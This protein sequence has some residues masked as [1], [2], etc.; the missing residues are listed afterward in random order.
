M[1][2]G[3]S[4]NYKIVTLSLYDE[5]VIAS[6]GYQYGYYEKNTNF[7]WDVRADDAA[8]EIS[9]H[10]TMDIHEYR[11]FPCYDYL[12]VCVLKCHSKSTLKYMN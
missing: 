4:N 3:V 11:G 9:I 2:L 10:I 5:N 8:E 1:S 12:L 6:P 7:T